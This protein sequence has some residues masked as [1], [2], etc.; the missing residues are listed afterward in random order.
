MAWLVYI[1]ALIGFIRSCTSST[2]LIPVLV[3]FSVLLVI[4][5]VS[6][7]F[8]AGLLYWGFVVFV[9]FVLGFAGQIIGI[10]TFEGESPNLEEFGLLILSMIIVTWYGLKF[11][12]TGKIGK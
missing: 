12:Q 6:G 8:I 7:S 4:K 11:L 1:I 9:F 2:Q 3:I 5:L 10:V